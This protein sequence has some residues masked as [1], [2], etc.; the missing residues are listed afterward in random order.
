MPE[1]LS[2][3]PLGR[4][5]VCDAPNCSPQQSEWESRAVER[6]WTRGARSTWLCPKHAP[7][8]ARP[9]Q[10]DPLTVYRAE[11]KGIPLGLYTT[12][13]AAKQHCE[14]IV[15]RDQ[16]DA[17]TFGRWISDDLEEPD[18]ARTLYLPDD[19]REEL[20]SGCTVTRLA[21]ADAYD[22]DGDE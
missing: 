16:P 22:Q 11:H 20:D 17:V 21:V 12:E 15:R 19:D 5:I 7:G 6:G 9:E 10:G 13:R 14:E 18:A 2:A 1:P 8:A 4:F 3:G